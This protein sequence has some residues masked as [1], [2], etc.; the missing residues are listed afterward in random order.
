MREYFLTLI[1][2]CLICGA[3]SMLFFEGRG[4]LSGKVNLV[5]AL[6]VLSVVISPLFSLISEIKSGE[7]AP[8]LFGENYY[9]AY[10]FEEIYEENLSRES[11]SGIEKR[12]VT[13][14]SEK[15]NISDKNISLKIDYET[16]EGEIKILRAVVYLSGAAIL[17]DPRDVTDYM[18]EFLDCRCE[19]LYG[20]EDNE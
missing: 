12:L 6:C 9:D 16:D 15:F 14:I 13:M 18:K 8:L 7:M 17:E 10:A 19:V 3:A 4:A 20:G 5:G 11:V 2:V 1:G